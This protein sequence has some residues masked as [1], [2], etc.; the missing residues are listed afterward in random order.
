MSEQNPQ[1]VNVLVDGTLTGKK[2]YNVK[3]NLV[4]REVPG[5]F[6]VEREDFAPMEGFQVEDGEYVLCYSYGNKDFKRNKT[7]KSTGLKK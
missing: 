6:V 3:L 7:V 5:N 1:K 2:T 4:V